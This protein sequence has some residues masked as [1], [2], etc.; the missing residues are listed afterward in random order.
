[1]GAETYYEYLKAFGLMDETEVDMIGE[2]TGIFTDEKTFT[3][4]VAALA[5]YSFGQTFNVTP[6]ALTVAIFTPPMWWNRFWMTTAM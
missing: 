2:V 6:L 1:M 5:S 3:T 4:D